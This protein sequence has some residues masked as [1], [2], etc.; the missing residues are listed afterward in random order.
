LDVKFFEIFA[1]CNINAYRIMIHSLNSIKR[2]TILALVIVLSFN[3]CENVGIKITDAITGPSL[4]IARDGN[5]LFH[6]TDEFS[7]QTANLEVTGE[8]QNQGFVDF[9]KL[10]K[11]EVVLKESRYDSAGMQFVGAYRYRGYSLFDVL[12]GFNQQKKNAELFKPAIDLYITIENDANEKVVFSWSE[13]FHTNILHQILIAT[14]MAPIVPYRKEVDYPV[15]SRW[16]LVAANDLFSYRSLENPVKITVHSFDKKEFTINRNISPLYSDGFDIYVENDHIMHIADSASTSKILA[17]ESS[18]YGMGM[19]S[20]PSDPFVGPDL[21]HLLMQ[22]VNLRDQKWIE[23]GLVCF[24]GLDGYRSVFS[25]SELFNRT[26]QVSPILAI[27]KL[28][29]EG[30]FYRLFHPADFYADRSVKSLMEVY[31]F[32]D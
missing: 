14:D 25:F 10:Y 31:F 24:A 20:H 12:N 27:T 18:F 17:Y 13:I 9:K 3:S 6:Q 19:G 2:L 1:L 7:L 29:T 28:P 22:S 23:Q 26:D 32:T 30:G 11:R 5:S 8:V 16:K 4:D 21:K 15:A